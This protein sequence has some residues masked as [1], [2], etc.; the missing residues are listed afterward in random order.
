MINHNENLIDLP[1]FGCYSG[2][3]QD[4]CYLF[5]IEVPS[6]IYFGIELFAALVLILGGLM[7]IKKYKN[8]K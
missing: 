5:G 3:A 7:L 1:V 2:C 4:Y 6:R 8:K